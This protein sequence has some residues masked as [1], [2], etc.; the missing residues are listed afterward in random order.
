LGYI[1]VL[2]TRGWTHRRREA[3]HRASTRHKFTHTRRCEEHAPHEG[4]AA[5]A[6]QNPEELGYDFL[7]IRAFEDKSGEKI[8]G[9]VVSSPSE[10][11]TELIFHLG[12]AN[13]A[14]EYV[15]FAPFA[16][17]RWIK[18]HLEPKNAVLVNVRD[19]STDISIVRDG[20]PQMVRIVAKGLDTSKRKLKEMS[21]YER[22]LLRAN[23]SEAEATMLAQ[24][25]DMSIKAQPSAMTE[26][27]E[28]IYITGARAKDEELLALLSE[29]LELP[30]KSLRVESIEEAHDEEN[31][32]EPTFDAFV[33]MTGGMRA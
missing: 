23:P 2:H 30:I 8:E 12:R 26:G 24:D 25:I 33:P 29:K 21:R 5:V 9:L 13:L 10:P 1:Q 15:E 6:G 32:V 19:E 18:N 16:V 3:I 4:T 17:A 7:P 22:M 31:N 11:L 14:L 28:E 20:I 27:L